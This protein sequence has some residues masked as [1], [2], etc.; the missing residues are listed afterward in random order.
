VWER[1]AT[2]E[3]PD[4]AVFRLSGPA[5]RI[6]DTWARVTSL[7]AGVPQALI[8]ASPGRGVVRC[9]VPEPDPVMLGAGVLHPPTAETLVA[10]R[11][12]AP[13]WG[14]VGGGTARDRLSRGVRRAFDPHGILNPG[15]LGEGDAA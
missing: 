10:E 5:A 6:A 14:S 12:P 8:H 15:I 4:A 11:L 2:T 13:L 3:P 1:L 9:I 7:L